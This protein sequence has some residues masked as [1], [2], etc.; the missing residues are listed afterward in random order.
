MKLA[1]YQAPLLPGGS[2]KALELIRHRVKWCETEG[3]DI[4]C[5]PEA[6]LGGLADDVECPAD[7]AIDVESGQLEALLAPLASNSVTTIVGFTETV[8]AGK[9]YNS[10]AVFRDGRVAGIYRKRHPAIKSSVYSAG[11]QSPVFTVGSLSFGIMICNDSNDPEIAADMVARGAKAIFLPSN[12]SLPPD[13][14]DVVA[15]SRAVDVARAR[16]N[17]VMIVR[18]DVAG[19]T[20]D[21]VL[22]RLVRHCRCAWN[23]RP[24]RRGAERGHPRC[25]DPSPQASDQLAAARGAGHAQLSQPGADLELRQLGGATQSRIIGALLLA[26]S[27]DHVVDVAE[28]HE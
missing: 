2:M 14:A 7:I 21:R 1:A 22:V 23:G 11:D 19:R 27:R 6:V 26:V 8:G 17:A 10:A 15:L 13:R 16:D 4:L 28:L 25:G 5:C 18:A 12:N 9:L 3:V 20:A 24:S